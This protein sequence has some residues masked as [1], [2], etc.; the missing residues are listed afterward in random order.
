MKKLILSAS[1]LFLAAFATHAQQSELSVTI[2]ASNPIGSYAE[3]G[4]NVNETGYAKAGANFRVNYQ[5]NVSDN[6]GILAMLHSTVNPMDVE[7][8]EKELNTGGATFKVDKANWALLG[9]QFGPVYRHEINEKLMFEARA[10]IGYNSVTAPGIKATLPDGSYLERA[11]ASAGS[12]VYSIGAGVKI[13]LTDKLF[14]PIHVDYLGGSTSIKDVELTTLNTSNYAITKTK[15]D[16]TMQL[17]NINTAFGLG[18][19]F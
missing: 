5:Y 18:F 4:S 11:Q 10:T 7:A 19:I 14:I 13:K 6:W 1:A 2:G 16:V 12:F 15:T 9:L 17:N 8:L 3:T